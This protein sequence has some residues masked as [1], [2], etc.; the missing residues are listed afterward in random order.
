MTYSLKCDIVIFN[1]ERK[2]GSE[3]RVEP[4]RKTAHPRGRGRL[5]GVLGIVAGLAIACVGSQAVEVLSVPV[6]FG[7]RLDEVSPDLSAT[8]RRRYAVNGAVYGADAE[9]QTTCPEGTT[10]FQMQNIGMFIDFNKEHYPGPTIVGGRMTDGKGEGRR[11]WVLA[12]F[13]PEGVHEG[14]QR[15]DCFRAKGDGNNELVETKF[16]IY[17]IVIEN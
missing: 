13:T 11:L 10:S 8:F 6:T 3:A 4:S 14:V 2:V 16:G 9:F 1:M 5:V 17:R 12:D 7:P 15:L